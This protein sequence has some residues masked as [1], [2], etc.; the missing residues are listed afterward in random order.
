MY[1]KKNV[2]HMRVHDTLLKYCLD[3]FHLNAFTINF[4]DVKCL[5]H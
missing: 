3:Y 2:L 5:L 1:A 4:Y